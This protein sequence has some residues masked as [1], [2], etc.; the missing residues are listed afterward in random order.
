MFTCPLWCGQIKSS[1]DYAKNPLCGRVYI[2]V[3]VCIALVFSSVIGFFIMAL[4]Y[5]TMY[6]CFV[7][8]LDSF[9]L[10]DGLPS[11]MSK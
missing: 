10:V 11:S 2:V 1:S 4:L 8:S 6:S 5:I 9:C 3:I 7:K